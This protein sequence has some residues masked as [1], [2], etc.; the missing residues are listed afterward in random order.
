LT[1]RALQ[2]IDRSFRFRLV[3]WSFFFRHRICIPVSSLRRPT[4]C[5][6]Q[7]GATLRRAATVGQQGQEAPGMLLS[8]PLSFFTR[9]MVR[10]G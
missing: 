5:T 1:Q 8:I 9:E 3:A 7:R 2:V 4:S 6:Q 10:P